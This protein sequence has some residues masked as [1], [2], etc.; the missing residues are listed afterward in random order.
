LASL[1][2]GFFAANTCAARSAVLHGFSLIFL[3]Q[4][5]PIREIGG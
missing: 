3:E 4:F 1:A 5:A 2:Q